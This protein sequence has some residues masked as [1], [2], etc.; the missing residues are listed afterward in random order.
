MAS[1]KRDLIVGTIRASVICL[2]ISQALVKDSFFIVPDDFDRAN[3]DEVLNGCFPGHLDRL[4]ATPAPVRRQIE[5][6]SSEARSL[7]PQAVHREPTPG[8]QRILPR[9]SAPC[10]WRLPGYR[11]ASDLK[12]AQVAHC[13]LG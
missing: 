11:T 8:R 7:P 6:E 4:M 3:F 5:T 12:Q 13:L 10:A 1:V 9:D 2:G